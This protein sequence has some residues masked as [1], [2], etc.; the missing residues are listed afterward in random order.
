MSFG[1]TLQNKKALIT[2]GTK[3]I[4]KAT[5]AAFLQL[6]ASVVFTARHAEEV[7]AAEAQWSS[8]YPELQVKG[9]VADVSLESNRLHVYDWIATH[10]QQLDVL[11]NNAGINIRKKTPEYTRQE[12]EQI[13]A[14]NML[15]PFEWARLLYPLLKRSGKAAIVNVASV[16]GSNI[17][18]GT[19]SPYAMSKAALIQQT[20]SLAVEWAKE[21]IRVNVVSP[22]YTNTPLA[23]PVLQNEARIAHILSRTPMGRIAQPEEIAAIIAFLAMD[24]SSYITGQNIIA[25]GGLSISGL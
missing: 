22:W 4:G 10:W 2:G 8:Q 15:A 6:G 16:A 5:V 19:G 24:K 1:W 21:G 12:Y 13:L 14:I 3:G 7:T 11:V 18:I 17:D 25:D 9:I 20:R 23:A